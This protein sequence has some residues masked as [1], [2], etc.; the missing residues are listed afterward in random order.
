MGWMR[1]ACG[2]WIIDGGKALHKAIVQD[3]GATALV[4]RCQ[5]HKRR[6]VLGHPARGG[7]E[8]LVGRLRQRLLHSRSLRAR[9]STS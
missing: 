1:S 9:R 3:F 6:N 2:P 7:R 5:K 4:Q 8:G